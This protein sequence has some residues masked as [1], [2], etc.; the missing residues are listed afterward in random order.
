VE[1]G[2]EAVAA[3]RAV[4]LG[5]LTVAVERQHAWRAGGGALVGWAA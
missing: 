4:D 3:R 5:G 1:L 2:G